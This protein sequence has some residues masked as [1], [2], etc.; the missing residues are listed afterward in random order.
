M[1]LYCQRAEEGDAGDKRVAVTKE[2]ERHV[3]VK[4]PPC[5][6]QPGDPGSVTCTPGALA[7]QP[8]LAPGESKGAHPEML[9]TPRRIIHCVSVC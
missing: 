8:H 7:S 2:A 1:E 3:P 9:K 5:A 4:T 6:H